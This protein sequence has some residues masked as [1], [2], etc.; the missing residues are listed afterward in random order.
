[1]GTPQATEEAGDATAAEGVT[2]VSR[3]KAQSALRALYDHLGQLGF[4]Q[5]HVEAALQHQAT[6]AMPSAEAALHWLCLNVPPDQL[7]AKFVSRS[8]AIAAAGAFVPTRPGQTTCHVSS[9]SLVASASHTHR[10]VMTLRSGGLVESWCGR[11]PADGCDD[12]S[13]SRDTHRANPERGVATVACT[14]GGQ[15]QRLTVYLLS[16]SLSLTHNF[17]VLCCCTTRR[18]RGEGDRRGPANISL[19]RSP[20]GGAS[21][22]GRT[23]AARASPSTAT[24]G[25]VDPGGRL[26]QGV[27]QTGGC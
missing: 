4:Q 11:G 21:A 19:F 15:V 16:L 27:D 25:A 23:S 8:R 22:A 3:K 6:Q 7:P 10:P 13:P 2:Y 5:Q 12:S 26:A 14:K 20:L 17:T 1:M 18:G 24:Q 9:L